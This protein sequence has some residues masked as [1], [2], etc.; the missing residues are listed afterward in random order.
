MTKY[1]AARW[2]FIEQ[3]FAAFG[4]SFDTEAEAW[5]FAM[6]ER[7]ERN[8]DRADYDVVAA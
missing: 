4:P 2:M 5:S 1:R 7:E 6:K 8:K 3:K